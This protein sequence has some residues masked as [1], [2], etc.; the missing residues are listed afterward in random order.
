M[1]IVQE[2]GKNLNKKTIAVILIGLFCLVLF[3]N[4]FFAFTSGVAHNPDGDT[5]GTRFYLFGPDPYYN[6]RTCEQTMKNGYYSPIDDPLLNY[7]IGDK[8]A[9][10]PLFNMIAVSITTLGGGSI[11]ALGWTMLCLPAIYGALLIFPVYSIGKELFNK[12]V[13]LLS[14]MLLPI[15]PAHVGAGHGSALSLFDHDS[16]LLLLFTLTFFFFL[17]SLKNKDNLFYPILAGICL[18]AIRLTW[19]A[20]ELAFI[21]FSIFLFVYLYV[22]L[23]KEESDVIIFRNVCITMI[24]GFLMPLPYIIATSGDTVFDITYWCVISCVGLCIFSLIQ[25]RFQISRY[26]SIPTVS[27]IVAVGIIF[28]Y[29]VDIGKVQTSFVFHEISNVVFGSGI[30]GD[31][32]L[33]TIGESHV[34]SLSDMAFLFGPVVFW[35]MFGGFIFFIYEAYNEKLKPEY[36]FFIVIFTIQLWLTT[37]AGRFV[38]D[39]IPMAIIFS[40]FF[41]WCVFKKVKF[42]SIKKPQITCI[43]FALLLILPN[44]YFSADQ[45]YHMETEHRWSSV[46]YWLSQQDVELEPADRP[47]ILAWWDYGFFIA[48]MGEHPT[49]ADN[50]QSGIYSS[51]NFLTAITEKEAI[52]VLI[53]RIVEGTKRPKQEIKGIISEDVKIVFDFYIN[54]SDDLINI[55]ED[56]IRY[57]PSYNTPYASEWINGTFLR[58]SAENAMY[59]DAVSIITQLSDEQVNIMYQDLMNV[60]SYSIKYV[61]VDSRDIGDIFPVISYSA[62]K[63]VWYLT[64]DED[65]YLTGEEKDKKPLFY[66]TMAYKIFS[67]KNLTYFK[68]VYD[69]DNVKVV[70]YGGE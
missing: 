59:W 56:P 1:N 63:G 23:V 5:L 48:S 53:V 49:V 44:A 35:I 66:E 33:L 36:I 14:A 31:K 9:R 61:G 17:K 15:I 18:G 46:C 30:Y 8:G 28:L 24:I 40:A 16:F 64:M 52:A 54:Q 20:D 13:G 55:I 3:M 12:K 22:G 45:Q 57:A 21:M 70:E 42:N 29:L 60:T 25:R 69:T 47:A 37:T 11:D 34:F 43:F 41:I 6:M 26:V 50:Y 67:E 68:L 51:S 10:P 58:V 19:V 4:S 39:M 27:G 38:N 65:D 7:P 32:I 2:D 62:D